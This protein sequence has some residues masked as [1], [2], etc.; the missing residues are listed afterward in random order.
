MEVHS[1]K[2]TENPLTQTGELL[3]EKHSN[4]ENWEEVVS[5]VTKYDL[6][7]INRGFYQHWIMYLG[8]GNIIH[9]T[10][11]DG[12]TE[13]KDAEKRLDKIKNIA[14]EDKCRVNNHDG[15]ALSK[16]L[17]IKSS[18]EIL[19]SISDVVH[20]DSYKIVPYSVHRENCEYY[21]TTWKY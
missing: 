19:Q 16:S 17:S 11:V 14:R 21:V 15:I 5:K 6:I 2:P 10:Q 7:E 3:Q 8:D 18:E 1:Q 9:V 13:G 4:W 12:R 20:E